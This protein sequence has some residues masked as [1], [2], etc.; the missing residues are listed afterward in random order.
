M[1]SYLLLYC[2][3]GFESEAASEIATAAA[4][5]GF[6]GYPSF[7]SGAGYVVFVLQP[8]KQDATELIQKLSF[9]S[10]IFARQWVA[11]AKL[12]ES[13]STKDRIAPIAEAVAG[14]PRA[15]EVLVEVPDTTDGRNLSG[16]AKKFTGAVAGA[17]RHQQ[18]LL[19]RKSKS[20]W[21]LHIFVLSGQDFWVGVSP[22]NNSSN[23]EQGIKRLKFPS[24]APSRSTLKLE[25]AWHQFVRRRDWDEK[26]SGGSRAV[27]LGAA[28]GGWTYQLVKRG[29][30]VTAVD[31]GPMNDDLMETGQVD[32]K[33]E[34]A[35][36]Y[37]PGK[38]VDIMVCDVV[39]KPARVIELM[40]RWAVNGWARILIFNLKLP[41]KRRYEEVENRLG[42]LETRLQ[43]HQLKFHLE[44]K[45]L[46]HDREEITCYLELL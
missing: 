40:E 2:R 12:L 39:D 15:S 17:L 4:R 10:L 3:S 26:L 7:E 14:L 21:R 6:Y 34:D 25:E 33:R 43:E 46:Y 29:M 24:D 44:A 23:W 5:L 36:T 18:L 37:A 11:C 27:D 30:F 9:R 41:M 28:P 16:F 1:P 35:F 22:I 45:H 42:M 8:P 13:V 19:P 20:N 31:N 32:H 38:P